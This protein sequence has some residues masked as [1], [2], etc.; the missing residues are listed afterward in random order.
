MSAYVA[1]KGP[2]VF[3]AFG[4]WAYNLSGFNQYGLHRDD[5][6][7]E[8]EDVKEAIRRLPR[9]LYDERNYR[10]MRAIHLSMT[11]TILPKEEWTKYEEDT[12]Y[13]EPYLQ[14][15]VKEREEREDWN[16]DH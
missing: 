5:C 8:T 3:S 2:K 7:Y 1:R 9:K 14:E 11:K 16:K 13:L 4:K 6:L 15:V 10:I 12:K